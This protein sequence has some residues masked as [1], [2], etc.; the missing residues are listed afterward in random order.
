MALGAH[1]DI[2]EMNHEC[3]IILLSY[4]KAVAEEKGLPNAT[5]VHHTKQSDSLHYTL[6]THYIQQ[7][8]I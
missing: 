3:I 5:K 6:T 4:Q 8:S 7:N 1:K 2:C